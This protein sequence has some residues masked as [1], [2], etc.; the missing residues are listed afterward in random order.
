MV[1]SEGKCPGLPD[2]LFRASFC[3]KTLERVI[4]AGD[5][6]CVFFFSSYFFL[7]V[8]SG[9]ERECDDAQPWDSIDLPSECCLM[10]LNNHV[11]SFRILIS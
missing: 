7:D 1:I 2:I 6:S 10:A 5:L 3:L 11:F 9:R 8:K 4:L